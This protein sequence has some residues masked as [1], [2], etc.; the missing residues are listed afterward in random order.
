MEKTSRIHSDFD[1]VVM[2]EGDYVLCP[3][4][5][6]QHSH[7]KILLVEDTVQYR[8]HIL[9]QVFDGETRCWITKGSDDILRHFDSLDFA[10]AELKRLFP[11]GIPK[12]Q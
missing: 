10:V 3:Q 4:E 7:P 8:L 9:V 2:E 1:F 12:Y 5:L 11:N 6:F